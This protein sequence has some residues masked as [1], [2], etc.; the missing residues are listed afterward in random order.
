MQKARKAIEEMGDDPEYK[1]WA[2]K[3]ILAG[4]TQTSTWKLVD[5]LESE[6]F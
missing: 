2:W 4:R 3:G 6:V 5:S 1:V